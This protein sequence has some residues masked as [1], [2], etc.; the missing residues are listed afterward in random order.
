MITSTVTRRTRVDFLL[1]PDVLPLETAEPAPAGRWED[2]PSVIVA[3]DLLDPAPEREE[4]DLDEVKHG[5]AAGRCLSQA[6]DRSLSSRT[7]KPRLILHLH[8]S[9]S[10]RERRR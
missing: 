2:R 9:A 6:G 10:G 7:G 3:V 8:S 4:P 1:K 5:A